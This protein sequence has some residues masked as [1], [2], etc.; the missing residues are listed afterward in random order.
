MP[1]VGKAF[2]RM[3]VKRFIGGW[4]YYLLASLTLGLAP[5]SPEPHIVGK[6]RWIAGG[7]VGMQAID[8]FDVFLHGTPW[9]LLSLAGSLYLFTKGRKQ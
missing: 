3:W 9:L 1:A 2:V 4:Q 7:A 6:I 5:F 8:W